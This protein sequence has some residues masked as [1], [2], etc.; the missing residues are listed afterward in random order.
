MGGSWT[1]EPGRPSGTNACGRTPSCRTR[2]SPVAQRSTSGNVREAGS[3]SSGAAGACADSASP[4][5]SAAEAAHTDARHQPSS[6]VTGAA[7]PLVHRRDAAA[8]RL[9]VLPDLFL[10]FTRVVVELAHA[11]E[12]EI[13]LQI[14]ERR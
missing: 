12:L 7:R 2:S 10:L 13:R 5:A 4:D 6:R 3:R 1:K 11:R 9:H 14:A 8:E